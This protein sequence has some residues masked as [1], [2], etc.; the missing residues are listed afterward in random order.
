MSF[1]NGLD[2][3]REYQRRGFNVTPLRGKKP[4]LQGWQDRELTADELSSHFADGNNVGVVLGSP[5]GLVDI[6]LDNPLAVT[7]AEALLPGTVKSGRVKNPKSH[8]WYL[9][10]LAPVSKTYSISKPMAE[11]LDS[12]N[13]VTLVEL[14]S[15]GRQ[16]VLPPSIHP[17]DGDRYFWYPGEILEISGEELG[18]HVQNVAIATLL[19][20]YWAPG[21]RQKLALSTAGYLGRHMAHGR[22]EDIVEATAKAASD[23]EAAKRVQAAH[24]TLQKLKRGRDAVTGGPILEEVAPGVPTTI[25]NWCGWRDT[26]GSTGDEGESRTSP[27]Q[28]DALLGYVNDVELFHAPDGTAHATM[29][30]D[31]HKEHWPVRGREF[32]LY[33]RSR[34]FEDRHRAPSPQ[35]INDAI[36]T[37]GAQA[38]FKGSEEKVHLRVAGHGD[39]VYLDLCNDNWEVIE[40]TAEGWR[41]VADPPVRFGRR[42]N[43]AA[44]PRP[45]QGG[46]VDDLHYFLNVQSY[47]H[48]QLIVGWLVGALNPDGPYPILEINGQQGSAKSTTMRVLRSLIDPAKEPLRSLPMSEHDLAIA[49]R[50]NWVLAFDNLSYIRPQISDALCRISNGGGF[51]T[52][53]LYTDDEE[54]L[55]SAKRP[56]IINGINQVALR[57][58]LQ[59]RSILVSL[60]SIPASERESEK[61]FWY[62]F[63]D[64]HPTILGALLDA[65]S[66][67]LSRSDRVRLHE[68]PRMADFAIWVDGRR[69]LLGLGDRRVYEGL[70]L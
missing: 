63:E 19:A 50:G 6:D 62:G 56:Q 69:I 32:G 53:R 15:T 33:L 13:D 60:P 5:A 7:A 51:G 61:K 52:R 44:L 49:A 34:F 24:G 4:L 25:A 68:P 3:A 2:A 11:R 17:E 14:R 22:V 28:T 35:S 9:C 57:G 59:E 48:F 27:S 23:E 40:I 29:C 66:E 37:A 46:S 47:E 20:L 64:C 41:V 1:G 70:L 36:E 39:A 58:D 16:T 42:A 43:S 8:W 10:T 54:T 65:V 21:C 31:G 30:K 26:E 67:A 55:F 38:L 12:V 18:E 45:E